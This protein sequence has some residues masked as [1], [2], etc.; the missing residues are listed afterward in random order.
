MMHP[1]YDYQNDKQIRETIE[2]FRN[3]EFLM[4]KVLNHNPSFGYNTLE[5][6]FEED[7]VQALDQIINE[8]FGIKRDA[9][10]RWKENDDGIHVLAVALY[11]IMKEHNYNERNEKFSDFVIRIVKDG[12]LKPGKIRDYYEKFYN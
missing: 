12:I 8:K 1:P 6:L 2:L 5:G 11:Q 4:D 10:K 3:D 7:C 9:R